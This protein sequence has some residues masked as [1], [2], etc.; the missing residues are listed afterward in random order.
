MK[1]NNPIHVDAVYL[2]WLSQQK[3]MVTI[4]PKADGIYREIKVGRYKFIAELVKICEHDIY[5]VFDTLSYPAR[6]SSNLINRMKWVRNMHPIAKKLNTNVSINNAEEFIELCKKDTELLKEYCN[7]LDEKSSIYW[8]P[9]IVTKSN[10]EHDI[11]LKFIDTSIDKY[12]PYKTDGWI[13]TSLNK[14]YHDIAKYKPKNELTVDLLFDGELFLWRTAEDTVVDNVNNKYEYDIKGG[15]I[16][17]CEM[18]SDLPNVW[19][20]KDLRRDKIVP[21]KKWIVDMLEDLH[22]NYWSATDLAPLIK[23]YYYD[24]KYKELDSDTVT[25]LNLQKGIF[26]SNIR[27]IFELNDSIKNVFDIGCGKGKLV[28]IIKKYAMEGYINFNDMDIVGIDIDA[29]NIM[30]ARQKYKCDNC[31]F[32]LSSMNIG[33]NIYKDWSAN[34]KY[35]LIV[36]N[37]TIQNCDNLD[38]MMSRISSIINKGGYLYI[39]FIDY[40]SVINRNVN[41]NIISVEYIDEDNKI[42]KFKY[43]WTNVDIE[44]KIISCRELEDTLVRYGYTKIHLENNNNHDNYPEKFKEFSKCN[45]F[46]IYQYKF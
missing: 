17:R 3:D 6:H 30:L 1:K 24:H 42:F 14:N 16:W 10:M 35:D 11:F 22:K 26:E 20:P 2:I 7:K 23:P 32:E 25:Y 36:L 46:I 40:D 27:N 9:K 12:L 43:P 33:V 13:I 29:N 38:K 31:R 15:E 8:Y 21:N 41:N 45:K 39:H 19:I 37:N 18:V 4:S 34:T 44:E 5:L 28:G